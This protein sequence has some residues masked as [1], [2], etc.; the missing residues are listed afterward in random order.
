MPKYDSSSGRT[1]SWKPRNGMANQTSAE[2]Q[3]DRHGQQRGEREAVEE[4]A[5]TLANVARAKRLRHQRVQ[6]Q[7]HRHAE[8]RKRDVHGIAD[9]GGADRLRAERADHDGVDHAHAH[10]AEL[11]QHHGNGEAQHGPEF[12][13]DGREHGWAGKLPF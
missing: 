9:A 1:A 7:H 4:Q 2:Q 5:M 8:N 11:G 10:P 12:A 6:S 13:S 3:H